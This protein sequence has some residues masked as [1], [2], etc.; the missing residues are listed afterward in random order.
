MAAEAEM[1]PT[2]YIGHHLSFNS[3]SVGEGAFWSINVDTVLTSVLLGV[4][5]FGFLWWVVRGAT[6]GV[7]DSP[8]A[9]SLPKSVITYL[10][11]AFAGWWHS[12]QFL[13]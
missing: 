4:I 11:P 13:R 5:G 6:A 1:T 7:P 3:R 12:P 2:E 10:P 9:T 8:P